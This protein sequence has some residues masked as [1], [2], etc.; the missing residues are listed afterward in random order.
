MET[1]LS[2]VWHKAWLQEHSVNMIWILS[3][4][5]FIYNWEKV[6]EMTFSRV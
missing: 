2:L 6:E 1:K 4:L 3:G 5:L